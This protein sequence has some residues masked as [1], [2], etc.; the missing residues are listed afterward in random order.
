VW[1][2]GLCDIDNTQLGYFGSEHAKFFSSRRKNFVA[3][4][5]FK[6]HPVFPCIDGKRFDVSIL[7]IRISDMTAVIHL[8]SVDRVGAQHP[9]PQYDLLK[10]VAFFEII[11]GVRIR[12][13]RAVEALWSAFRLQ[14]S[15]CSASTTQSKRFVK[16]INFS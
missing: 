12:H 9:L 11:F 13:E 14:V 4:L 6:R 8:L 3:D 15:I 7:V 1:R 5:V 10:G 2:I 16:P